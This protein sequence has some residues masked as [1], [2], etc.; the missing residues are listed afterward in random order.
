[1]RLAPPAS[2]KSI[3]DEEIKEKFKHAKTRGERDEP[4]SEKHLRKRKEPSLSVEHTKILPP[5]KKLKRDK[6]NSLDASAKM[7][8]NKPLVKAKKISSLDMIDTSLANDPVGSKVRT[9][10]STALKKL[11]NP[12]VQKH[13]CQY[14][15]VF[16][17]TDKSANSVMRLGAL[18]MLTKMMYEHNDDVSVQIEALL[19]LTKLVVKNQACGEAVIGSGCVAL[20]IET[21]NNHVGSLEVLQA[22]CALF[23]A[24]SYDFRTHQFIT[25]AKGVD[26]VVSILKLNSSRLDILLDG[27][28]FLQNILC[29][30]NT[31]TEAGNLFQ[32]HGLTLV[33]ADGIA[34]IPKAAYIRVACGILANLAMTS[35]SIN[36]AYV[37]KICITRILSIMALDVDVDTKKAAVDALQAI[38]IGSSKMAS[39]VSEQD[40][41]KKMLELIKPQ[42]NDAYLIMSGLKLIIGVMKDEKCAQLFVA[43]DGYRAMT[44]QMNRYYNSLFVQASGCSILRKLEIPAIGDECAGDA[45]KLILSALSRFSDDDLIQFDGR[46]ALLNLLSQYPSVAS[47]L[48]DIRKM[49]KSLTVEDEE[50]GLDAAS[51][52]SDMEIVPSATDNLVVE[53]FTVNGNDDPVCHKIKTIISKSSNHLDDNKIQDK[54]IEQLRKLIRDDDDESAEKIIQLGGI[55]MIVNAMKAHPDKAVVQ[56]EACATLAD[57]IWK[58]PNSVRKIAEAGCFPLVV[59][60]LSTHLTNKHSKLQ[61][62]GCGVFYALSC[63]NSNHYFINGVNGLEAVL[64][65]MYHNSHKV[66]VMKQVW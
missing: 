65:S 7:V 11:D 55:T 35:N 16:I 26:A 62:M 1:M 24:L 39:I 46:H 21:M 43:E 3:T 63:E 28:C 47:I 60:A 57:L 32:S 31:S 40:G 10:I 4:R 49:N 66:E 50:D 19:T 9:L 41:M 25:S 23:R 59:K 53:D 6:K 14:I 5:T 64:E 12:S 48:I 17:K 52:V 56:A 13:A 45:T 34:S 51:E 8:H 61:Q 15:R 30:P 22:A 20:A 42:Q 38:S 44:H 27:C 33:I 58:Y 54:S 36:E 29:N 37:G 18:L 2:R